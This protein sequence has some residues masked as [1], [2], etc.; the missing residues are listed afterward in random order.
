MNRPL[1]TVLLLTVFGLLLMLC[2]CAVTTVE[3]DPTTGAVR[4]SSD[5]DLKAT[6]LKI[7]REMNGTV[8]VEIKSLDANASNPAAVQVLGIQAAAEGAAKGAA[9]GLNPIK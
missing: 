3:V 4:Y 5:K 7:R 8:E 6:G 1:R 9:A 2:S